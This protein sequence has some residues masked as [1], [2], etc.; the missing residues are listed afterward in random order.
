MT[1]RDPRIARK[2][3]DEL[4][5]VERQE[6]RYANEKVIYDMVSAEQLK[7][8]GQRVDDM[9]WALGW[10]VLTL[11]NWKALAIA[12]VLILLI[13]GQDMLDLLFAK[14]GKGLE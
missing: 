13:G 11:R 7:Q 6:T 1:D 2:P 4:T 3:D 5:P 10:L 8:W 12:A 9:W 14:A